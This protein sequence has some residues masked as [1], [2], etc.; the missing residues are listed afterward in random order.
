LVG[1]PHATTYAG[2]GG[3][4]YVVF[5]KATGFDRALEV[6][7]LDGVNGFRLH[8]AEFDQSGYSVADAGDVNRDGF[9]DLIIGAY[10][11][12]PN[13]LWDAGASYV[14]FGVKPTDAVSRTGTIADQT[15]AGGLGNDTLRGLG[16]ND[17]LWGHSGNDRMIGGTGNDIIR[18]HSG[19]DILRGDAG[20]DAL[21]GGSGSDVLIGGE[22]RDRLRGGYGADVFD[23]NALGESGVSAASR[24]VIIDFISDSMGD[25]SNA[26]RINLAT[27]DAI[28]GG[29]DDAFSFVGEAK[30]TGLGQVRSFQVNGNTFVDVNV[31][32]DNAPDMRIVIRGLVSLEVSDFIL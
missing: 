4:S 21:S 8:G 28:A 22:G 6:S 3:V 19:D 16:G 9:S 23:F 32:G 15:L 29:A 25:P 27:V 10:M 24:D 13:G 20:D 11:A 17:A 18:A 14:F 7:E 26:D 5:G 31:T 2:Y 12:D 1:T 30:F